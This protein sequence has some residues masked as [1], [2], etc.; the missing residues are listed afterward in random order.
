[1]V[2]LT[3]VNDGRWPTWPKKVVAPLLVARLKAL[4]GKGLERKTLPLKSLFGL[5][6][7]ANVGVD[8]LLGLKARLPRS[9]GC[10]G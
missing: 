7:S 2:L 4:L 8:D 6:T 9:L 1:M 5:V 3:E 10:W